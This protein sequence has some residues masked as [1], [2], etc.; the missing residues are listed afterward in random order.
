M[1]VPP[2]SSD[3]SLAILRQTFASA[4]PIHGAQRWLGHSRRAR[5]SPAAVPPAR[6]RFIL[7]LHR[8]VLHQ[9]NKRDVARYKWRR[10]PYEDVEGE[11]IRGNVFDVLLFALPKI[12]VSNTCAA[13]LPSLY[14]RLGA[15]S[16]GCRDNVSH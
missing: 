3:T 2:G 6:P 1:Q 4:A 12:N 8:A 10:L 13:M 9:K 14:Q 15:I 11:L 5:T 7:G 16:P